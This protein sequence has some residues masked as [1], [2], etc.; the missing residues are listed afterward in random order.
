MPG[1]QAAP[2]AVITKNYVGG[3]QECIQID[4]CTDETNVFPQYR[5]YD[6]TTCEDFVVDGNVF[7][8]VFSGVGTHSMMSGETYKRIT[9]T[10]NTFH[11]IKKTLHR[12]YEL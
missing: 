3:G 5:P 1:S 11:N 12:I 7:S 9:V 4:C 6:G 8:D 2:S 10:N